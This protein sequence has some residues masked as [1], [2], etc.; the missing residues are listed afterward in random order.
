MYNVSHRH[1]ST[2]GK[3]SPSAVA[4]VQAAV[5]QSQPLD[6]RQ[7]QNRAGGWTYHVGPEQMLRRWLV[8][9]PG[10]GQGTYYATE[11]ELVLEAD[12]ASIREINA[13]TPVKV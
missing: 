1:K 3:S 6:E 11:G 9:G 2:I 4:Q 7:V 12:A 13:T 5:P 8:L 10:A